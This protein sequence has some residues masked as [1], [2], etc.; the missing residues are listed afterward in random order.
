MSNT[1]DIR[2]IKEEVAREII[3]ARNDRPNL[4]QDELWWSW[5]RYCHPSAQEYEDALDKVADRYTR[6]LRSR[7]SEL[8][9]ENKRLREEQRWIPYQHRGKER[10]IKDMKTDNEL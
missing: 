9:A 3:A 6:H 8:E 5:K 1:K 4:R 2:P 7:I 10:T